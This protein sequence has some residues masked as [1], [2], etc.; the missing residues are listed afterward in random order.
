MR[1]N[2]RTNTGILRIVACKYE[3]LRTIK[4]IYVQNFYFN[5]FRFV[6]TL[7]NF[8]EDHTSKNLAGLLDAC[9][10][11]IPGLN[12]AK[13][14]LTSVND[15][16][17]NIVRGI[18]ISETVT[19]QV[20]C[21]AHTLQLVLNDCMDSQPE[22]SEIIRKCKALAA[23]THR[24]SKQAN[25]IKMMCERLNSDSAQNT[26]WEYRV[27]I[28]PGGVRWNS[29][30]MCMDSVMKLEEPLLQLKTDDA[31]FRDITP[32]EEEFEI[33]EEILPM[34]KAFHI[35]T[36]QLSAENSITMHCVLA[37]LYDLTCFLE[38][39]NAKPAQ[40]HLQ[41]VR[42]WAKRA[43]KRLSERYPN[44]GA[45]INE[46]ALGH[47]LNPEYKG[48]LCQM[49]N[50][51]SWDRMLEDFIDTNSQVIHTLHEIFGNLRIIS[52]YL[53]TITSLYV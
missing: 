14:M 51:E 49:K 37:T 45:D 3:F 27:I 35:V 53:R 36:Q 22:V 19:G 26:Q 24:S 20:R 31:D 33:L 21:V 5:I 17:A 43:L 15:N 40:S 42:A 25:K 47:F 41:P 7:Q 18:R 9:I 12:L 11:K 13:T 38:K 2:M 8:R 6:V 44:Y 1:I 34:L 23:L 50:K 16:A 46:F 10:R 28:S 4:P 32:S 52:C 30:Y 29:T 48:L 39:S